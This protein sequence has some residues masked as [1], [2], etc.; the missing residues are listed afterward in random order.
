MLLRAPDITD[1]HR[2]ELLASEATVA[3]CQLLELGDAGCDL[4]SQTPAVGPE[5][6][7]AVEG[8]SQ[9]LQVSPPH[10]TC[11]PDGAV[12]RILRGLGEYQDLCLVARHDHLRGVGPPH[13]IVRRQLGSS[14]R[15][16]DGVAGT[17][18][19]RVSV[20]VRRRAGDPPQDVRQGRRP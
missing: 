14:L 7:R 2:S 6:Q 19:C 11:Y 20:H 18:R 16:L 15:D 8:D 9:G 3:T 5:V 4:L 1:S 13:Q 12:G 10:L 17:Q